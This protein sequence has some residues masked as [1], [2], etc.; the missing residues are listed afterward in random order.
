MHHPTTFVILAS[1]SLAC[2]A[3][4]QENIKTFTYSKTK[5][6]DL[7]V[8]VH[9]PPGWKETDRRP[10]IVFFFG[11]GWESGTIKQFEP[12]AQYLAGRGMIAALADYRVKS[13]HGVTPREC[14]EDAR[15]AV[16]WLRQNAARLGLD[17]DRIVASGGSAGGHIAACT[18]LMPESEQ[19]GKDVSCK[20]NA[21]LLFNPVLRFSPPLFKK[22]DNDQAVGKAI[23]PVLYLAKDSPPTLLFFGTDDF[24][25]QQGE[26]FM[27][28]S[29]ELGHRAEMFTAEKQ[30][31]GF[32]NKSPWREKTL[33]RADEFLVSLRYLQG[34]AT[35][36]VPE[37]EALS[38]RQESP[39]ARI[40]VVKTWK[41]LQSQAPIELGDGVKVRLGLSAD[42]S[43]Q[44]SSVLLYCLTEGYTPASRGIGPEPLGPVHATFTFGKWETRPGLVRWGAGKEKDWPKAS[45]LFIRVLPVDQVGVYKVRVNHPKGHRLAETTLEGTNDAFH[46]WVPW[47]FLNRDS[48]SADARPIEGIALPSRFRLVPIA[49]A[50]PG[51][52]PSGD[53]PAL[54]PSAPTPGF[55]IS[56]QDDDVL[57][58]AET[59]FTT[60]HPDYHLLTR[61][62]V[63]DKPFVPRQIKESWVYPGY[64]LVHEGKELRVPLHFSPA[65]LRAK[66]GDKIG[67][68]LLYCPGEWE[69][70]NRMGLVKGLVFPDAPWLSN[71]T[72]FVARESKAK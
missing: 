27:Q 49:S 18:T 61:W 3:L 44:W 56:V 19:K 47:F 11:G 13:R 12:Q 24:L 62:W 43:P 45:Y 71:R 33:Q 20:A 53:L 21:L 26:E 16:R 68:Q 41:D 15:N 50:G 58:R 9:F 17:P 48:D 10:G 65:R 63:N 69:W 67:L 46:P 31:H 6:A 22:I 30:P 2:S 54:F 40:A 64:G 4:G 1:L 23:S 35:I 25:F 39:P 8:A 36:K 42:R 32:F 29:R 37:G 7:E 51:K 70:C 66:P 72:D 60:S 59:E 34:K 14:V 57:I 52:T 28:R 38:P 5:Q 55:R